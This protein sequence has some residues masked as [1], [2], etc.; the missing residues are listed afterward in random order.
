MRSRSAATSRTVKA[1]PAAGD[2]VLVMLGPSRPVKAARGAGA[3][4]LV[5]CANIEK[6]PRPTIGKGISRILRKMPAAE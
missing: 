4:R 1:A 6:G 3:M 2:A 5:T